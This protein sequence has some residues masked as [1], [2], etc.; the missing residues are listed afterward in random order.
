MLSIFITKKTAK[1]ASSLLGGD[2]TSFA[3]LGIL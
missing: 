2:A 3:D 1:A